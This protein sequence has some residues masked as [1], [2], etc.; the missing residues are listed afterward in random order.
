MGPLNGSADRCS[1]DP[2]TFYFDSKPIVTAHLQPELS[3]AGF[4]KIFVYARRWSAPCQI[5]MKVTTTKPGFYQRISADTCTSLLFFIMGDYD[6]R[7][8]PNSERIDNDPAPEASHWSRALP[9]NG[10][11]TGWHLETGSNVRLMTLWS[12]ASVPLRYGCG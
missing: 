9:L 7:L 12:L 11:R 10:S 8:G 3:L 6:T 2:D 1:T 5:R 4:I